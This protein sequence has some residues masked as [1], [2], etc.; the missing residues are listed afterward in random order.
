MAT[1]TRERMIETTAALL[2]RRGFHGTSLNAILAESGSP[3]GSLYYHFPGGKEELVLA[4]MT[5][6][7][8][9]A[10]AYLAAV[11][12]PG[13][14]PVAGLRAY[15][16]AAADELEASGYLFG[17]PVA[18]IVLDLS[19]GSAAR[20][21]EVCRAALTEWQRLIQEG[22][23]AAGIAAPRAA[24]LAMVVVSAL[25]GGLL[26]ARADR[27]TAPLTAVADELARLVEGALPG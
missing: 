2:H 14:D 11:M 25:E 16:A 17:C 5:R 21:E 18:P 7:I 10:T 3:R 8:E 23:A 20:L 15:V 27:D 19:D 26:L 13:A 24:S 22:L 12:R 9:Q 1:D 4:A 6:E